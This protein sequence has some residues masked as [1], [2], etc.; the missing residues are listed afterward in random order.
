MWKKSLA[1][2]MIICLISGIIL[3]GRLYSKAEEVPKEESTATAEIQ[4]E[5]Q[6]E[7][8][9]TAVLE[10]T[11]EEVEE[12]K[13]TA[14]ADKEDEKI[15]EET[16]TPAEVPQ[17]IEQTEAPAE[18]TEES[19]EEVEFQQ[20]ISFAK[21][22]SMVKGASNATE[23]A[24]VKV[25]VYRNETVTEMEIPT[26]MVAENVPQDM[27]NCHFVGAYVVTESGEDE[28]AYIG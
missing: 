16:E 19:S 17:S 1:F 8:E 24:T 13:T 23:N 15:S 7:I 21:L 2:I 3:N 10:E 26:G 9:K 11:Q 27:E 6:K 28:I 5:E 22:N 14:E 20:K 4:E 18:Q 25:L 12:E